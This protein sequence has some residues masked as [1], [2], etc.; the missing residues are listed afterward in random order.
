M[1]FT[2]LVIGKHLLQLA[3]TG[4]AIQHKPRQTPE[5]IKKNKCYGV[6]VLFPSNLRYRRCSTPE[7]KI[8]GIYPYDL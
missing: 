4:Y 1:Y 2:L 7:T 6:A 5:R 8:I 3:P